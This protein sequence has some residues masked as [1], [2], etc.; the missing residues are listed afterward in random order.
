MIKIK[1][2]RNIINIKWKNII[3]E[4]KEIIFFMKKK[5]IMKNEYII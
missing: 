1:M 4:T 3:K 2:Y 5:S